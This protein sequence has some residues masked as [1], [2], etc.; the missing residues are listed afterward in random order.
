MTRRNRKNNGKEGEHKIIN[1]KEQEEERNIRRKERWQKG[2]MET[3]GH[4]IK[5]WNEEM[6]EESVG[7]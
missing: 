5:E 2:S 3:E 1:R 4:E 6:M 7:K